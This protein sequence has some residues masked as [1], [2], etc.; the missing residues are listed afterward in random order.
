MMED[1]EINFLFNL[2]IVAFFSFIFFLQ[3][4]IFLRTK[5]KLCFNISGDSV[6]CMSVVELLSSVELQAVFE[7]QER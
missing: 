3:A 6:S 7:D 5:F 4:L 1:S 2:L